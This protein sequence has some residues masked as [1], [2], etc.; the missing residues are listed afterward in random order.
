MKPIGIIICVGV[1]LTLA[2]ASTMFFVPPSPLKN[3][4]YIL[5]EFILLSFGY[6]SLTAEGAKSHV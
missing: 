3:L 2:V 6:L 1:V 4:L 5:S